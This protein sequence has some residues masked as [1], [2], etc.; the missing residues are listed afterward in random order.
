MLTVNIP[1]I[2]FYCGWFAGGNIGGGNG[3]WNGISKAKSVFTIH[4]ENEY[5]VYLEA[6][7][8]HCIFSVSGKWCDVAQ[9]SGKKM[10][11]TPI[12]SCLPIVYL[13]HINSMFTLTLQRAIS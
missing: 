9:A 3:N 6:L 12:Q 4:I 5:I 10:S 13:M 11:S 2:F 1:K 8:V 7:D